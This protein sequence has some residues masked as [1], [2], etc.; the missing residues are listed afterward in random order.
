MGYVAT[1]FQAEFAHR[2]LGN[3]TTLLERDANLALAE[4][5]DSLTVFRSYRIPVLITTQ[6]PAL[7]V[8]VE[9]V[10]AQQSED[11]SYIQSEITVSIDL[12]LV[13]KDAF[14][15]QGQL[16]K[17]VLALDRVIRTATAA[18]LVGELSATKSQPVWEVTEHSFQL[19]KNDTTLRADASLTVVIQLFER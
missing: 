7:F 1:K 14:D 11:D 2:V 3:L 13:G 16:A 6:F 10:M 8:S 18:D 12:A 5:D 9:R 19:L 4:V 15:L 17:Y